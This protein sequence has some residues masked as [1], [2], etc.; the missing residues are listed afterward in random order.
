[1]NFNFI[2][3]FLEAEAQEIGTTVQMG[4]PWLFLVMIPAF[5]LA[6]FPFF[7]L[8]KS[9]RWKVK[10]VVPLIIHLL[11]LAIATTLITDIRLVEISKAPEET[12]VVVLADM[13]DSNSAM[14]DKMND[15]IKSLMENADE[16]TQIC[17]VAFANGQIKTSD[18][19]EVL[20]DYLNI[21][22]EDVDSVNTNIQNA[23]DYV[24]ENFYEKNQNYDDVN[25]RVILLSD[26]RQTEGNA[27]AMARKLR[28]KAVRFDTAHFNVLEEDVIS[29]VQML[30]MT[31]TVIES[32][33]ANVSVDLAFT[34][35]SKDTL[36]GKITF[37]EVPQYSEETGASEPKEVYSSNV[38]IK[39][40]T[41]QYSFK[42]M[43]EGAGIHSV[44]AVIEPEEN[45]D[46]IAQNN[47]LY[48]W[49]S[50]DAVANILLVDGDGKQVTDSIK[51]M[52]EKS[53]C[54]YTVITTKDNADAFPHTMD[55][56]LPYDE[57]VLMNIDFSKFQT[58]DTDRLKRYVEELGRGVV[59]TCGS[60]TYDYNSKD[61]ANNPLID[62][63]PVDLKIDERREVIAT[64]ITVDL[65]SSMG[66]EVTGQTNQYGKKMTRYDMVLQS[67]IKLL[68]TKEFAPDDYI[69][70]VFFDSDA[71]VAM[72]LTQLHEKEWMIQQINYAFESYFYA[73]TDEKNPSYSNRVSVTSG[74]K[75]ANGY[76]IKPYGTNYKFGIDAA[77]RLLSES[78][79][80]LK[81]MVFLSDGEPSDK[82]SGYDN[83][84]RRMANAGVTTSTIAI[85]RDQATIL[86]D[87]QRLATIGHGNFNYVSSSLDLEKSLVKIAQMIKGEPIN[88]RETQ[89]EKR[90]DGKVL[91]G[92]DLG[93]G[94]NTT[95]D[96][97]GGY[98]GTTIKNGATTVLS[99]DDLRPII[100]EWDYGLGHTTVYMSDLGGAWSRP[101][102]NDNDGF[103]NSVIV[104]NLLLNSLNEDVGSTGLIIESKR[105]E[106]VT[107]LTV[108]TQK[109]LRQNEVIVVY[110]TSS[111]GERVEYR[112][113][114]DNRLADTKYRIDLETEN[115]S[116]TYLIEVELVDD[117]PGAKQVLDRTQYAVVGFYPD[118]Y[119]LGLINGYAVMED[120]ATA[121]GGKLMAD[122]EA[123][124]DIKKDEFRENVTDISTPALII[125]IVLFLLDIIFR[126][127]SPKKKDKNNLMTEE[128]RIASMRGR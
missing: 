63:L 40:G 21:S 114:D 58:G 128:E 53:G 25:N 13:S 100:A 117:T 107:K 108:Q 49:F 104:Q 3:P 93:S 1:M 29:E 41:N 33:D 10:H 22:G 39:Q 44:Y 6:I 27:F 80:D 124:Y 48:S 94:D 89:L 77:N 14:K 17:V 109:R 73:H 123:F 126:H 122:S 96:K 11:I 101:L 65:S 81:Q 76:Q 68:D 51:K 127:F 2:R 98:Y 8:H 64:V 99:A 95:F 23:L 35:T 87:L 118:E 90:E 59:F 85:G 102:F 30:S 103:V 60:N 28:E 34:S 15:Y 24:I 97:I 12:R 45:G 46:T 26:G 61:Y 121:G 55:E 54:T 105:V 4:R 120:L 83:T 119:N 5:I 32:K 92:V 110:V 38:S 37:Y 31:S 62:I 36:T 91:V 70:L 18:Y 20:D 74:T 72:P 113:T 69:G 57:V 67:V 79:A 82:N 75:D 88:E 50:I 86:T 9:R 125:L 116:G 7:R 71:T 19:G 42:Y 16:K 47:V 78:D 84:V 66:Q 56:L 115:E 43:A 52:V 106:E 111:D 112:T